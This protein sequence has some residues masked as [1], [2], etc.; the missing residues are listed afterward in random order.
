[1]ADLNE[2]DILTEDFSISAKACKEIFANCCSAELTESVLNSREYLL[3][4][5]KD[6]EYFNNE[7]FIMHNLIKN[8]PRICC[9]VEFLTLYMQSNK[10]NLQKEKGI[11]LNDFTLGGDTE[12][13]A[14]G[15]FVNHCCATLTE[16]TS[17][18]GNDSMFNL[19][20][21]KYKMW[22]K[23]DKAGDLF[24]TGM[25]ILSDSGVKLGRSILQGYDDA[26]NYVLEQF[27]NLDT[28][29][30]DNARRG[31]IVYGENED[32]EKEEQSKA[33]FVSSFG[34]A[35]LDKATGGIYSGDMV[36]VLAP[37]KGG[38]SRFATFVLHNAVVNCGCN[39]VAWS[40]ENGSEGWESLIRARHFDYMYNRS[41][42]DAQTKK[43]INN[44]MIRK[45][46]LVGDMKKLESASWLD[47]KYNTNYGRIANIDED[48]NLETFL[49]VLDRAV[50]RVDA[51][52]ICID[53]LQLLT[54]SNNKSSNDVIGEA[55]K[56]TLQFLKSRKIAGIF[57]AQFKQGSLSSFG[58]G[59]TN[60]ETRDIGG[61]SYE[62]IK[63]PDLNLGLYAS[64]ED[65]RDG[66]A[67]IFSIPSRNSA[68]FEDINLY[69]ELGACNFVVANNQ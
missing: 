5:F 56:K 18:E 10:A 27:G 4:H 29:N 23:Y 30:Q 54:S 38:K 17:A 14:Y 64:I 40:M 9:D 20:L 58:S 19:A 15:E 7:W 48:F 41:V 51:G 61:L 49:D 26:K 24:S 52:L 43:L 32:T 39:V 63:T 35:P 42:L 28:L 45:N 34:I 50:K 53:Y 46:T 33:K 67:K 66:V 37:S 68:P 22:Y 69:T 21:E 1:M 47:L 11:N 65:L 55:Y 62:V 6:S 2:Q 31:I 16:C 57:P 3:H 13:D 8:F 44:D 59:D 25:E 60:Q 36:S 12:I